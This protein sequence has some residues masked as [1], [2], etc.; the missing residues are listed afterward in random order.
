MELAWIPFDENGTL[1]EVRFHPD[2]RPPGEGWERYDPLVHP[3]DPV[4]DL[5]GRSD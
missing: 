4:K 5:P 3:L 1:V 2:E